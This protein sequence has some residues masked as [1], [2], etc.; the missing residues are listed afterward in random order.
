MTGG[1]FHL[2]CASYREGETD[3]A[4]LL[5][6]AAQ[7]LLRQDPGPVASGP[8]GNPLFPAV[9]QLHCSVTH[10]GDWWMCV[11][12]D[13]PVGLDLQLRRTSYAHPGVLSRRFF[14]PDEDAFLA[15]RAYQDFFDLWAA[16]ES[17]VKYTCRGFR[18]DP[19]SFSVVSPQGRFPAMDGV[20]LRLLPFA[21]AYSL[22][23]CARTIPEV[24]IARL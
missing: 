5:R 10:S 19:A 14:H 6:R 11:L 13:Q 22:C 17:W 21:P 3:S 4:A 7:Q 15:A 23:L 20:R 9:P 8:W 12:A 2:R 24:R 16:K 18:D 1:C